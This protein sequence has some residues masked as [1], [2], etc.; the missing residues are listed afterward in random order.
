MK[1]IF[2]RQLLLIMAMLLLLATAGCRKQEPEIDAQAM[3]ESLLEEV[4]FDTELEQVGSNAALYFP[5]L[6]QDT[7]IQMYTG[8]GYFAD[9]VALLTLPTAADCAGA[10]KIVQNHIK[11]LRDQFMFYVPEELDKIDHA[12]TYQTGKYV[13]LCITN[14]YAN[15]ERILKQT[16]SIDASIENEGQTETES[17]EENTE[18]SIEPVC[19]SIRSA[20]A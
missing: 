19:F 17:S 6:P 3:L 8:S 2:I 4:A 11:E 7:S 16:G 12:V 9:E 1:H 10:M 18:A 14:D 20:F 15:A 13:F 5:D